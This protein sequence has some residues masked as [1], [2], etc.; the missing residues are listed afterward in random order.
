MPKILVGSKFDLCQERTISTSEGR[1]LAE[2]Y[3]ME[4]IEVSAK[5]NYNIDEAFQKIAELI[6]ENN[7]QE[8]D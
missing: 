7:F 4:Y 8:D 1:L 2:K 6:L 3:N 5:L